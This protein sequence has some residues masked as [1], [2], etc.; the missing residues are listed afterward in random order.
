MHSPG[1]SR[2]P[3]V[4]T[5]QHA[6]S[7]GQH[8]PWGQHCT[9]CTVLGSAQSWGQQFPACTGPEVSLEPYENKEKGSKLVPYA[10]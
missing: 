2:G 10:S 7:W 4:S 6:Q 9:A 8:R 5:A 1:V 3:G